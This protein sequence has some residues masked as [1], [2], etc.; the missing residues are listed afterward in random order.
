MMELE[1][2]AG[3]TMSRCIRPEGAMGEPSLAVFSDKSASAM[4]A[5]VYV[6]WD[7]TPH[8]EAVLI[9]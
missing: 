2:E 9:L 1:E 8:Q 4:C 5:V 3:V 7:A 6:V